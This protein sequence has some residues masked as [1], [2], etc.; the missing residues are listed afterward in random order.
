MSKQHDSL[1]SINK[2]NSCR[3]YFCSAFFAFICLYVAMRLPVNV[4]ISQCKNTRESPPKKSLLIEVVMYY[5]L[6]HKFLFVYIIFDEN[7][8][9]KILQFQCNS[10]VENHVETYN[11]KHFFNRAVTYVAKLGRLL[12]RLCTKDGQS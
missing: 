11:I 7:T 6:V 9:V 4:Q 2:Y 8:S 10:M 5:C 1:F 12:S 3:F